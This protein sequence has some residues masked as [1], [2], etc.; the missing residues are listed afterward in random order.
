MK[1]LIY[2]LLFFFSLFS[3]SFGQGTERSVFASSGKVAK[4]V[5]IESTYGV[6]FTIGETIINWSNAGIGRI[7]NG[8]Q[9]SDQLIPI[10]FTASAMMT[11][12]PTFLIYPNPVSDYIIIEGAEDQKDLTK[13]QLIDQNGKLIQVELMIDARRDMDFET[14]LAPGQYFLG[15]YNASDAFLNKP[16]S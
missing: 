14:N 4:S 8:P 2:F 13:I 9:Q 10:S 6:S 15:F 5:T 3:T 12:A 7:H 11:V 16:K 1:N